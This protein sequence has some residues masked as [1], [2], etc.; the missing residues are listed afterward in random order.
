[1][2]ISKIWIVAKKDLAE[3]RTNK[4]IIFT[5]IFMPIL[6]AVFVPMSFIPALYSIPFSRGGEPLNITINIAFVYQGK[7]LS[8]VNLSDSR[9]ENSTI[10]DS[11]I[12]GS[13][14]VNSR[15]EGVVVNN[16]ELVN[17][18][19]KRSIV[20]NSN[21]REITSREDTSLYGC[22]LI[23]VEDGLRPFL[24][25]ILDSLIIFFVMI[26]AIIPTIIASYSFIGEKT[27][28]SLEPLLATPTSDA[29]LLLGKSLSILIPTMLAT[30]LAFI[31]LVF[32]V[33]FS[34]EPLVSYY[35][36]PTVTW[37]YSVLVIG[38]LFCILSISLNVY[39]SSKVSDVRASQQLGS[40]VVLPLVLLFML[41][42][43]GVII[44]NLFSMFLLSVLIFFI[45]VGIVYLGAETFNREKILIRWK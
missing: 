36:V 4:Y 23:D 10:S 24:A 29:E 2:R 33:D 30:W 13:I 44:P 6:M 25:Q 21:L 1:M 37:L 31:V 38:P 41:A 32:L 42:I 15:L 20:M 45:D 35:P 17:V 5:L 34:M 40:L 39:V 19:M 26:P 8:G 43:M 12:I 18:S 11:T 9:I 28:R 16:S 7:N 27:N 22:A 3:F 14:I